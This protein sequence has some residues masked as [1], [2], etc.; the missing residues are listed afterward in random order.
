TMDGE[1]LELSVN[2]QRVALL[3]INPL[4]KTGDNDLRTPPINVKAGPQN[5]SASFIKRGDGPIDDFLQRPERS[6]AD[7]FSG[8]IPGLTNP[9]HLRD[10]GIMGPY[11]ATGVSQTVSR[12]KI[13]TCTPAA[14]DQE[15]RCTREI[16][17][18]L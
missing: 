5:I 6:L 4:M 14:A 8:Q 1:Q 11:K 7:D 13:L 15:E 10:L 9:P 17:P 2:G 12:R 18:K 3:D 16:I